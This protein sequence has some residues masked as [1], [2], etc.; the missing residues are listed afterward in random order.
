MQVHGRLLGLEER[1]VLGDGT[2][3]DHGVIVWLGSEKGAIHIG[4]EVYIG[5][6]AFLGTNDHR[7]QI[8]ENSMVGAHCY[9]ITENH[10][11]SRDGTPFKLQPYE[12]A[13]VQIGRNVWLGCHVTI[14][15][16]VTIGD[17]SIIGAGAVV[18]RSLPANETWAGV[19]AKK[20]GNGNR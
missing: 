9:V 11:M 10:G 13:D 6:Y 8:G 19:P 15:P 14:L 20:I 7:L 1:L 5:P 3:L 18:T 2:H 4:K 12:G 17:N 16:G